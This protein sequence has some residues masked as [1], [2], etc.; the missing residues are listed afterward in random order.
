MGENLLLS[1]SKEIEERQRWESLSTG[2][3]IKE[4]GMNHQYSIILGGWAAG[5]ATSSAI[6]FRNKYQTYP[7]KVR[8]ASCRSR[9][10]LTSFVRWCR[11]VCGRRESPS[12]S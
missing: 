10:V 3:K 8:S 6:I 9:T 11:S 4:W 2:Q 5:I 12:L 7:Q 1:D